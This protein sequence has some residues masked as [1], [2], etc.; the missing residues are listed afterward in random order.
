MAVVGRP[1]VLRRRQRLDDVLLQGAEVELLELLGVVELL[2]HGV[3]RGVILVEYLQ[4]QLIRPPFTIRQ[5]PGRPGL[6]RPIAVCVHHRAFG[7]GRHICLQHD[8]P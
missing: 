5:A 4:I 2:A 3:G 1:P 7:F 6:G 8:F